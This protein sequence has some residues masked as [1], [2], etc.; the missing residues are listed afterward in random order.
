MSINPNFI[1]H[2][3]DLYVKVSPLYTRTEDGKEPTHMQIG[4][5]LNDLMDLSEEETA[6]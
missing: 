2:N 3:G 4:M 6:K 5:R 1:T